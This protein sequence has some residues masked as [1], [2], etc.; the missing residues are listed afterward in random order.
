MKISSVKPFVHPDFPNLVYVEVT[1]DEGIVGLGES[2]YFGST[3]AHFIN[4]FA[5]PAILGKDPLDRESI[6]KTLTTY[7]GYNSSGV[8]TRA[9][10]AIDIAL[11]DIAGKI[12]N[13]P[14]YKLIGGDS[15]RPLRIY[16]TCAGKEY[17][18]KSNQGSKSWGLDNES[19]TYE[20]LRAFMSDAGSLAKELLSE[21]VTA[22]KI[23]PFDLFSEKNWGSEISAADLKSGLAPIEKIR[24]AV[25]SRMDIMVELHAL[26]S[27]KAAKGIM[28]A[29]KEYEIYWVEDP[30]YPDNLDELESLRGDGMP[31]IAHGE[32]IAS[33]KRVETLVKRNLID[34]LTL[35][36]SW[37]G[38]L[39]EG[40]HFA[41]L[42]RANGVKIAPHDCTG[43]VG[44]T[45]GAHLSTADENALIQETVRAAYRTWYPHLVDGLPEING[46]TLALSES[47]GLGLRLRED[48]RKDLQTLRLAVNS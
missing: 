2:Y 30:I 35:D 9:R 39:T 32:T 8:E 23:W 22:M 29:L 7:V 18:R 5:G 17:M 1:T 38:G 33:R 11:W 19:N 40:L 3:V 20:D 13:K 26:W 42:A 44:L 36:L 24:A 4:E 46:G 6:S 14:I 16:N 47:A 37:C 45:I 34:V 21:G 31:P 28:T 12:A 41:E 25:G 10:S 43:P 48:F 27:P 15:P